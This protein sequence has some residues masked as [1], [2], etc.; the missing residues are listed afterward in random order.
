MWGNG[1]FMWPNGRIYKG[2]NE[3]MSMIKR[4]DQAL[5]ITLMEEILRNMEKYISK[6]KIRII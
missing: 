3:I 5:T 1:I 6:W 2:I 4:K